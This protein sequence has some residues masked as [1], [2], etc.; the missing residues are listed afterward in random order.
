MSRKKNKSIESKGAST[1]SFNHY[2]QSKTKNIIKIIIKKNNIFIKV[3]ILMILIVRGP[4][5]AGVKFYTLP[6]LSQP[7]TSCCN[8]FILSLIFSLLTWIISIFATF[9]IER[10]I[11]DN[12]YRGHF[13][14]SCIQVGGG[15]IK[16]NIL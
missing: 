9:R 3:V 5:C 13:W 6:T 7:G 14:N 11:E 10:H 15:N 2:H 1:M 8:L 16:H 12:N 4:I